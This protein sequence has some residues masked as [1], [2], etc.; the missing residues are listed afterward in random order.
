VLADPDRVEVTSRSVPVSTSSRLISTAVAMSPPSAGPLRPKP[1]TSPA[2]PPKK[3]WKMSSIDP[4]P[5]LR[6]AQ[7]PERRPSCPKVS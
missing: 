7:P 2:A 4:K 6:G 3:A 5:E 1:K